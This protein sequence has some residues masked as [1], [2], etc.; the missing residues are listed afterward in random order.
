MKCPYRTVNE[1]KVTPSGIVETKEFKD[2]LYVSCPFYH[3]DTYLNNRYC[4]RVLKE[5]VE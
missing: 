3:Y 1:L 5:G 4:L 2:C